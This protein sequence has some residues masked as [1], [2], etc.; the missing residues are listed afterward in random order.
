MSSEKNRINTAPRGSL[1]DDGP[2]IQRQNP[3]HLTSLKLPQQW[4]GFRFKG[5]ILKMSLW[6]S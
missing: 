1:S 4:G 3:V 5:N 6:I 2:E